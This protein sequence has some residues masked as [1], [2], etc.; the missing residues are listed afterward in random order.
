MVK[1]FDEA[2]K[3]GNAGFDSA[4]RS[5]GE[6]NRGFQAIAAEITDY[7]KKIFDDGSKTFEQIVAARSVEQ[8]VDIQSA[9]ARKAYEDY[10]AQVS[11]IGEMYAGLAKDVYRPFE[12]VASRAA[13]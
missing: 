2:Q 8:V 7:T 5:F 12:Q 10:L 1:G 6:V 13:A 9:Y 4:M 3:I 11:K